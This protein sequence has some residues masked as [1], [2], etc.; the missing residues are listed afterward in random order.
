MRDS[1]RALV[2]FGFEHLNLNRIEIRCAAGNTRS[3]VVA[4][5]LGF[6]IEGI[7]CQDEWL[8]GRLVDMIV[9]AQLKK[10]WVPQK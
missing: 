9:Y 10:E 5:K 1:V 6:K 8:N 2:T 4:E 3:I 7:L